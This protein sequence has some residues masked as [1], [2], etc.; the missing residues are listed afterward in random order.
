MMV[1]AAV[2]ASRVAVTISKAGHSAWID[3]DGN[4]TALELINIEVVWGAKPSDKWQGQLV[5]DPDVLR[6]LDK[7]KKSSVLGAKTYAAKLDR[8]NFL[9]YRFGA[10]QQTFTTEGGKKYPCNAPLIYPGLDG[11]KCS[12]CGWIH[13]TDLTAIA[14]QTR[15]ATRKPK[16]IEQVPLPE[17]PSSQLQL[18]EEVAPIKV[19]VEA[20]VWAT[21]TEEDLEA[22]SLELIEQYADD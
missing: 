21:P 5:R 7:I 22:A 10:C 6:V 20:A 16:R 3:R 19:E 1:E 13:K 17:L 8:L 14:T 12:R 11:W 9:D 4:T 18:F 2:K 15:K